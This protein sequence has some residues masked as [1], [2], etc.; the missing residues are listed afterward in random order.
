MNVFKWSNPKLFMCFSPDDGGGAS[1]SS[2]G[3]G[4]GS[5]VST[6]SDGAGG[7]PTSPEPAAPSTP[8]TSPA[9]SEVSP[10]EGLG[11]DFGDDE[12]E[13]PAAPVAPVEPVPPS[14]PVVPPAPVGDPAGT[15]AAPVVPPAQTP[16]APTSSDGQQAAPPLSPSDPVGVA[17]ALEQNRDAVIAHLAQTRF[18][19]TETDL[20]E[21]ESDAGKAVPKLLA[22]AMYETQTTMYKFLAQ[23]VPGMIQRHQTVSKANS[24]AE[25]KFFDAHKALGLKM[26]DAKHREVAKRMASVYRQTNPGLTLD[27]LIADVGP[28]VAMALKLSPIPN[29]PAP[30]RPMPGFRPAVGG[31][32]ASPAPAETNE[33]IG[34]GGNFDEE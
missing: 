10:W 4:G 34:L 21:L 18:A 15:P 25:T 28:M 9:A 23:A 11:G 7:S 29:Q 8:S 27:Q 5:S 31:G 32:G 30:Q 12:I 1:P 22:R 26:D 6:P 13:V 19:L 17:T 3:D 33:W 16:Q 14:A 24:D 2:P 20:A